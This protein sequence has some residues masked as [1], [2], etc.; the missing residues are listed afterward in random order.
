L[1]SKQQHGGETKSVF[2]L[3]LMEIISGKLEPQ[4]L[5]SAQG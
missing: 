2:T 1:V 5:N 3:G 4:A